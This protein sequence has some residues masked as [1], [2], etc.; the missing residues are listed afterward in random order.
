MRLNRYNSLNFKVHLFRCNVGFRKKNIRIL[1]ITRI[2]LNYRMNSRMFT[3]TLLI[4]NHHGK[5]IN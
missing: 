2:L 5:V 4:Y 1:A 3:R